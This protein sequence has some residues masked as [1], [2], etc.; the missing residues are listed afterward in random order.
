MA[1]RTFDVA[2]I[3]EILVHWHAGRLSGAQRLVGGPV[4]REFRPAE[5]GLGQRDRVLEVKLDLQPGSGSGREQRI[6]ASLPQ[7]AQD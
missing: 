1:R 6:V 2:G 7:V 4:V 5:P 3:I